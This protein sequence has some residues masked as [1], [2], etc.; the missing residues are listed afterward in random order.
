MKR[1]IAGIA[2]SVLAF[3]AASADPLAEA[4]A[5]KLQCLRPDTAR[6]ICAA[7]SGYAFDANGTITSTGDVLLSPQPLLIMR[8][9]SSVTV[10]G[11]AVCGVAK[12]EDLDN[13]SFLLNGAQLPEEQAAGV[14]AQLLGAVQNLIGKEVCTAYVPDG[15]KISGKVSIDGKPNPAFD[16]TFIWVKAGDGYTIAP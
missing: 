16:Q 14:R 10:K 6:K 9:V 5:G 15:D 7:L 13:A 11:E 1:V 8:T 4:R 3:S 2:L 12:K